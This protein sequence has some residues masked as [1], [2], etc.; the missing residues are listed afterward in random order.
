MEV[1]P[2]EVIRS[3]ATFAVTGVAEVGSPETASYLNPVEAILPPL[4]VT[5]LRKELTVSVTE[6]RALREGYLEQLRMFTDELKKTCRGMGIDYQRFSS[7]ESLDV[8]LS[9]FLA[10][11]AASMK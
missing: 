3:P 9:Q 8:A 11:R 1:D 2:G 7:G 5:G 6:P 10:V 4:R